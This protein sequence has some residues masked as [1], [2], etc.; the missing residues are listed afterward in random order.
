MR[1]ENKVVIGK[2]VFGLIYLQRYTLL[3]TLN[4]AGKLKSDS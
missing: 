1:R 4:G 2:Y 3:S